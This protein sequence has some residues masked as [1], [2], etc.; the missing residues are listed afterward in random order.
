MNLELISPGIS[1]K[2][3][4]QWPPPFQFSIKISIYRG[5][6]TYRVSHQVLG[7]KLLK[8]TSFVMMGHDAARLCNT[9]CRA[10]P[11]RAITHSKQNNNCKEGGGIDLKIF[12]R[13]LEARQRWGQS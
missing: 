8:H 2:Y 5:L 11:C 7:G 4:F 13:N 6:T 1:H 3:I 10:V 12:A 9:Q